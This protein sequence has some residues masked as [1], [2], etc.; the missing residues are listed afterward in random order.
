MQ[1]V[2]VLDEYTRPKQL[3]GKQLLEVE[4]TVTCIILVIF[5]NRLIDVW[6]NEVV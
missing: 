1:A 4:S 6:R 2:M 5:L 3:R